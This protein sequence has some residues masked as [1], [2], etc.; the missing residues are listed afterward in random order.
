VMDEHSWSISKDCPGH[1]EGAKV[2]LIMRSYHGRGRIS[3][4][5]EKPAQ[6][7]LKQSA[8]FHLVRCQY[9]P[10]TECIPTSSE[11]RV[12]GSQQDHGD[13][14]GIQYC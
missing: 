13:E 3:R 12:G 7:Q 4:E 1:I 5:E 2:F 6:T 8:E 11:Q 9:M 10:S 14:F